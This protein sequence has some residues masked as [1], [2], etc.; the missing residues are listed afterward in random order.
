[1][2]DPTTMIAM[3]QFNVGPKHPLYNKFVIA[4][5][6]TGC[7]YERRQIIG[8]AVNKVYYPED[9]EGYILRGPDGS[10]IGTAMKPAHYE[11]FEGWVLKIQLANGQV[12][13]AA[14]YAEYQE[15]LRLKIKFE[16]SKGSTI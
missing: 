15:Y 10:A 2:S 13:S 9:P 3:V 4:E 12:I 14:E 1:M 7:G 16:G 6:N 8:K 11:D 5:I